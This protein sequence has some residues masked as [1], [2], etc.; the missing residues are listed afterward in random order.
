M[1]FGYHKEAQMFPKLLLRISVRELHN[2]LV[3]DPNDGGLKE[4][5]DEDDNII[6]NDAILR[7]LLP[8]QLK[9]MSSRY[10]FMCGYDC[11]IF[12]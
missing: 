1:I 12:C 6:I 9:Q 4:A 2:I 10:N 3:S 7:A 8:P 11:C 5:K